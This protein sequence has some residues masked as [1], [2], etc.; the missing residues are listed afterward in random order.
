MGGVRI[1]VN[2]Q[3][4]DEL[5]TKWEDKGYSFKRVDQLT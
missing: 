3:V 1:N 4:L 5:L 2:A